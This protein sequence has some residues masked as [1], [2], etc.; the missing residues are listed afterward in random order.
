MAHFEPA[1]IPAGLKVNVKDQYGNDFEGAVYLN[2]KRLGSTLKT[3]KIPVCS[4]NLTVALDG[5]GKKKV[6]AK[7]VAQE[8]TRVEMIFGGE[9][10]TSYEAGEDIVFVRITSGRFSMGSPSSELGR[11]LDEVE[12]RIRLTDDFFLSKTE[13]TQN[14]Y[15]LL[16][17][18][19]PSRNRACGNCPVERV[20]WLDAVAF[21]NALSQ[22][23]GPT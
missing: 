14:Q 5:R 11:G 12:R 13:V 21:A 23:E 20:S 16:T 9:G 8:V 4:E 10:I 22:K 1:V 2:G 18:E 7:L 19:K 3:H 6:K 17:N 15:E